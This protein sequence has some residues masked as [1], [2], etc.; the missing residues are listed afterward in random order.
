MNRTQADAP[1]QSGFGPGTAL[2][3]VDPQRDFVNGHR[4]ALPVPG[5]EA[6]LPVL[7]RLSAAAAGAGAAVAASADW[8]PPDHVSFYTS[9]PAS[10]PGQ[11]VSVAVDGRQAEIRLF[12]PHCVAGTPGAQFAEGLDVTHVSHTVLK[13]TDAA[14]ESLSAFHDIAGARSTGLA[15]WLRQQR[16]RT[17]FVCGVVAEFCVRASVLDGLEAGFRVALLTDAVAGV[18]AAAC[19][20]ALQEM[21]RAGAVLVHSRELLQQQPGPGQASKTAGQALQAVAWLEAAGREKA[22]RAT[23]ST[24]VGTAAMAPPIR[25]AGQEVLPCVVKERRV[26]AT[27]AVSAGPACDGG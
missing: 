1:E 14:L 17:L 24:A 19:Q 5:A 25:A 7:N 18:D 2:L 16:V 9:H 4:G 10:R 22:A 3:L 23:G 6:L 26:L 13:G 20:A 11:V 12:S 15:E 21:E 27:A 8:H